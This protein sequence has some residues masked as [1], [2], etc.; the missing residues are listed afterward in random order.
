MSL[1]TEVTGHCHPFDDTWIAQ[2]D[3]MTKDQA[4]E[5][6]EKHI[7]ASV[8]HRNNYEN[9][10]RSQGIEPGLLHCWCIDNNNIIRFMRLYHEIAAEE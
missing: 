10:M 5:W 8:R 4:L 6:V 9:A 3:K 1:L 7:D 2:L